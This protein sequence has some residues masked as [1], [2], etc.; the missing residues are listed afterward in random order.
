ME[1]MALVTSE[2]YNGMSCELGGSVAPNKSVKLQ[3]GIKMKALSR[4]RVI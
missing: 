1:K 2:L 3:E 4:T